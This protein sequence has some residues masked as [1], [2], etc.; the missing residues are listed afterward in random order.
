MAA[1]GEPH[2]REQLV[3]EIVCAARAEPRKERRAQDGAGTP[4]SIAALIVHRPSPESETRPEN[5]ARS[6]LL[7]RAPGRQVEQPGCDHAAAPPDF[8]DVGQVQIVLVELRIA[9][10]RRLGVDF[11]ACVLPILACLRMLNPS[12]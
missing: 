11:A 6:G 5:S 7:H 1:E 3:G 2:R 9:Q 12:A 8:G 10:R 4:S